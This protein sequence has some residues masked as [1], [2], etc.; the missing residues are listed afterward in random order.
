MRGR[1]IDNITISYQPIIARAKF[2]V[3]LYLLRAKVF[4]VTFCWLHGI[5]ISVVLIPIQGVWPTE[6]AALGELTEN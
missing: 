1:S 5:L 2:F 4:Q 3:I 6:G